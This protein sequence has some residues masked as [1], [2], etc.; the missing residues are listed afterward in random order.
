MT[1]ASG[2]TMLW[3]AVVALCSGMGGFIS[4]R[5]M[6]PQ[7]ANG[8]H[9]TTPAVAEEGPVIRRP[10][11]APAQVQEP[12][13]EDRLY[14]WSVPEEGDQ[15]VFV[16]KVIDSDAVDIALLHPVRV[17]L[18]GLAKKQP[19]EMLEKELGGKLLQ[20]RFQG[21]DDRQSLQVLLWLGKDQGWLHERK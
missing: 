14:V 3:I 7:V 4:S 11:K 16:L 17:K 13:V 10:L 20:A 6:T 5:L 15:S 2:L 9:P 21:R 18:K 19:V 8:I 1:K 12:P